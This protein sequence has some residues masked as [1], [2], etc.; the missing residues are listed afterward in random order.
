MTINVLLRKW[1]FERFKEKTIKIGCI[2]TEVIIAIKH[3]IIT[4]KEHFMWKK[5]NF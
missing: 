4:F 5:D 2:I 3:A 1:S